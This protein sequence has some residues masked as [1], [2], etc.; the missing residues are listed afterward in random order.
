VTE[1]GFYVIEHLLTGKV[2][3]GYSKTVSVDVDQQ[4]KALMGE[5]HPNKP[6]NLL[7][8]RDAELLLLE[9]PAHSVNAAK[10][11]ARKIKRSVSPTY[12]L[13]NP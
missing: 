3:V 4:I 8:E 10:D 12:L 1:T 5:R 11:A 7:F 6:L 13:L 9:Y 2:L